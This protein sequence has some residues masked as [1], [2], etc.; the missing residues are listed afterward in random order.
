MRF[1]GF[2]CTSLRETA[3]ILA[4]NDDELCKLVN[5]ISDEYPHFLLVGDFNFS[6]IEWGNWTAVHTNPSSLKFLNTLL[7]NFLL[8]YLDSPTRGRGS[9]VPR[10]LDLVISNKEIVTKA[11]FPASHNVPS[12]RN[13]RS[14]SRIFRNNHV[15]AVRITL[16]REEIRCAVAVAA[17]PLCRNRRSV[18]NRIESYFFRSAVDG[19]PISILFTSTLC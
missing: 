1:D 9:N 2:G 6:D 19:Q 18:A 5:Y 14:F 10:I 3:D 4:S 16:L 7:D 13:V 11:W 12:V 17:V 15:S 8:Q